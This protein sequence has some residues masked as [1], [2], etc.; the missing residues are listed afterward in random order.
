MFY[1]VTDHAIQMQVNGKESFY[2]LQSLRLRKR[3]YWDVPQISEGDSTAVRRAKAFANFLMKK[4]VQLRE[5]DTFAGLIQHYDFSASMAIR[6]NEDY[7]PAKRPIYTREN[8]LEQEIAAVLRYDH[9]SDAPA[10]LEELKNGVDGGLYSHCPYGHVIPGFEF[11]MKNGWRAVDDA[12]TAKIAEGSERSDY[13]RAMQIAVQAARAY[14]LR[15]ADKARALTEGTER[16]EYR[17]GLSDIAESCERLSS[18]PAACFFDALQ[19]TLVMQEMLT[20]ET[21]SGSMSLGRMDRLFYPYYE[22]DVASK[23]LTAEIAQ[24]YIDAW[25]IKLAGLVQGFQNLALCGCDSEGKFA[26]NEISLMILRS[27]R[28]YRFDQPLLSLRYTKDMPDTYWEEALRLIELGDG[29]P[30][31]FNDDVI[32]PSR[33]QMGVSLE[34][35]WNYGIV[36]CVEPSI[37]GYEFSNTEEMRINWGKIIELMFHDGDCQATGKHFRMKRCLPLDQITSFEEFYAWF[38]DEL[39][40]TIQ[41]AARACNDID[42]SYYKYYASPLLSATMRDCVETGADVAD[43]TIRYHFSTINNCGMAN[44]VDS[45]LAIKEVVFDQKMIGMRQLKEALD[46]NFKGF[47]MLQNYLRFRCEKFGNDSIEANRLMRDLVDTATAAINQIPNIRGAHYQTGMYTVDLHASMGALT[48]ALPDGRNAWVSLANAI[49]PVQGAD[50]KGPTAII[51]S[52]TQFDHRQFG[53]GMVLDLKFSPSL[54]RKPAHR[55]MFRALIDAYFAK[56]GM[57]IQFN[58]MSRETLLAAQENPAMYKNLIVRVSGFSAYF[59]GL[60]KVLQ[61]EIIARTEYASVAGEGSK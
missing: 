10:D 19:L 9:D 25:R 15:Y 30:A 21:A 50:R 53:N 28:K 32:I 3:A 6:Y 33:I 18:E 14:L 20:S 29:F 7:H 39:C 47:E 45:L 52:V 37:G 60:D 51:N 40:F 54:F 43:S 1:A 34:D 31:V 2:D 46:R 13:C 35:A 26:G 17:R 49:A 16:E 55:K 59:V 44:A 56:G 11:I 41:K 23:K 27:A 5:F 22:A 24:L 12:L 57:E 36:G 58:V 61:D 48:A 42:R 4:P 38:K 8:D